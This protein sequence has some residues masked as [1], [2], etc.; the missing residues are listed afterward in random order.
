M[1][2]SIIP[3]FTAVNGQFRL[4]LAA[5]ELDRFDEAQ[6]AEARRYFAQPK[7]V[8]TGPTASPAKTTPDTMLKLQDGARKAKAQG[9][10]LGIDP[11]M[12]KEL[13]NHD[14]EKDKPAFAAG[15]PP[16]TMSFANV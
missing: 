14:F 16:G 8:V 13:L 6:R 10:D 12:E 11:K 7:T 2:P 1:S 9:L 5:L 15:Q 4:T 3:V